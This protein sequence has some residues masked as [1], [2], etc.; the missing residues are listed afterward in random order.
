MGSMEDNLPAVKEESRPAIVENCVCCN[1]EIAAK[2]LIYCSACRKPHHLKCW[3]KNRGCSI[4]EC[5]CRISERPTSE[6]TWERDDEDKDDWHY[7]DA[8]GSLVINTRAYELEDPFAGGLV[9]GCGGVSLGYF[10][11]ALAYTMGWYMIAASFVLF[12]IVSEGFRYRLRLNASGGAIERKL[13]FFDRVVSHDNS[14]LFF[15]ELVELHLHTKEE[16][17]EEDEEV[18]LSETETSE[19]KN[20][21]GDTETG[22]VR[23]EPKDTETSEVADK[24]EVVD[25]AGKTKK[26]TR[27]KSK[28]NKKP[29][30][31]AKFK[32]ELY[33]V[34]LD[35]ERRLM[36]ARK[37]RNRA[38]LEHVVQQIAQS[39][40][41]TIR[42]FKE[43]EKPSPKE[44]ADAVRQRRLEAPLSTDVKQ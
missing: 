28:K 33:G 34:N 31:P 40:D 10:F 29:K 3:R 36:F 39:A 25:K 20:K 11:S 23:D 16:P 18:K 43:G 27:T 6:I 7:A 22:E 38:E 26:K 12:I 42:R 9:L 14:Y 24:D 2:A 44:I 35:G 4:D 1:E 32:Y 15:D 41:V 19:D 8:D 17:E 5:S 13:L 30:K 37:T 21:L